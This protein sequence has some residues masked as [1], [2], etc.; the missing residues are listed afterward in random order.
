MTRTSDHPTFSFIGVTTGQSSI[1]GIFPRWM[2]EL[3]R[4]EV[5]L[6]GIDLRLHDDPA[7]YRA[8]I[9][10]IK[11]DRLALGG[12]V[13]THK[14]DLFAAARDLFDFLDPFATALAEVSSIAKGPEGLRGY[15]KDPITSGRTLDAML[16]EGYFGRTGGEVLCFGAGGSA[17]SIAA[18]FAGRHGVDRPDRFILVNRSQ[19]RLDHVRDAV[20]KLSGGDP[21]SIEAICNEDPGRN[22]ELVASMPAGSIVVNATGMGKD[23]PGSPVTDRVA[24]PERSIAWD[25]NYRGELRFLRQARGQPVEREVRVEDGWDYFLRGWAEHIAQVLHFE[26]SDEQFSTLAKL[27]EDTAP[28]S[29]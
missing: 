12:L 28:G 24:F 17:A 21:L 25:L 19:P 26:L 27:A 20:A 7:V 3:N 14:V 15:A 16:R 2:A 29:S 18:H 9:E 22:D 13:T 23:R 1:N 4:P 10:R 11:G 6:D 5:V 8:V